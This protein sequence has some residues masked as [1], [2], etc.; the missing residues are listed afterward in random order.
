MRI[1]H[2]GGS[3]SWPGALYVYNNG[4]TTL[5]GAFLTDNDRHDIY[6]GTN[7]EL[8][9]TNSMLSSFRF[10][11]DNV[12]SSWDGNIFYD[13]GATQSVVSMLGAEAGR[14]IHYAET[15]DDYVERLVAL[16]EDRAA[17]EA[18]GLRAREFVAANFSWDASY[19]ALDELLRSVAETPAGTAS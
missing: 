10:A 2:A 15:A 17:A 11:A 4:A 5:D 3:S 7:A 9:V 14:H 13:W 8:T 19:R 18:L 16:F 1:E 6:L 12:V